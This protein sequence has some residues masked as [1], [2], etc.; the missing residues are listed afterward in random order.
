MAKTNSHI[1]F[2]KSTKERDQLHNQ[3][4]QR[5]PH[6]F[7]RRITSLLSSSF[8]RLSDLDVFQRFVSGAYIYSLL[9]YRVLLIELGTQGFNWE[10]WKKEGGFYNSLRNSIDDISKAGITH[11]WLPP[12]SQSVSPE[13]PFFS[14][15]THH[16]SLILLTHLHSQGTYRESYTIWTAPNTV[17]KRN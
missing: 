6:D 13:G 11:I 3:T 14:L 10:S 1:L 9:Y 15:E 12:P 17:H 4:I 16:T 7:S 2:I 8:P 5:R